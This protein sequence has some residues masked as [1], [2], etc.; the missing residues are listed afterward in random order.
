MD[1]TRKAVDNLIYMRAGGGNYSNPV[2][3]TGAGIGTETRPKNIALNL[4][5]KLDY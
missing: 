5:V 1:L 3:D 4:Y 2:K